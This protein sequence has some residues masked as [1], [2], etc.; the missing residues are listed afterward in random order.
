[1]YT[2]Y[3]GLTEAPFSIAPNPQYLF[4]SPRHRDALAH[5]LYGVQSDGGFILLTGEV[6]TGKTTLCR[7]LLQQVPEDV[8]TAFVLNPRVTITELL[9]TICDEFAISYPTD[10]SVKALVDA[11]NKFLLESHAAHRR[12]VLI[13]DEAQNL[14]FELLEQLRL[15]TNLETNDRK[16]LQIVLLGQP[17]LLEILAKRELR[18]LS[19]R[20]TAR[21]HLESLNPE[22]IRDYLAH[23]LA[24][25]GCREMLF[26][27]AAIKRVYKLS[28]GV[29]RVINLICDRALLGAYS[30][31]QRSVNR[32][33][34]NRAAEE[35]LGPADSRRRNGQ[36][37]AAIA[38][39]TLAIGVILTGILTTDSLSFGE[40]SVVAETPATTAD[41]K[42][43]QSIA[44]N[45]A[46]ESPVPTEDF[47]A[48]GHQE[49]NAAYHDL[50]ALWGSAFEDRTTHP[51]SLANA[52]G[53]QCLTEA[54]SFTELRAINRPVIIKTIDGYL[55][56]SVIDD[57]SVTLFA[58]TREYQ[59]T[60]EDFMRRYNDRVHMIWR[61]PPDYQAPIRSGDTG[62]AV[63]WLVIQLALMDNR[64]PPM[65]T[66]FVYDDLA[67][68]RVKAFQR[69]VGLTPNGIVDP[70]TW[71][72]LNNVEAISIP[73]LASTAGR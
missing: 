52:I 65:T 71:I 15:L 54:L 22:E 23:R 21:Y 37:A 29:P 38:V 34:V 12:A 73:T 51:C 41:E 66:G 72:H 60:H 25:A 14:S 28:R 27:R 7:C 70:L 5:L 67:E 46:S 57:S 48:T 43:L 2:E 31:D 30:E 8:D 16:L 49:I 1:M 36:K 68:A 39:V 69:T 6:G 11:L 53:L 33:I 62:A 40:R 44:A 24:I 59:L 32:A 55:T 17:E 18:Q 26:T 64:E 50:F 35:V 58:G 47:S 19:Q 3:F 10:A 61:M 9:A 42:P 45:E 4:M 20:I 13:I 63:D 56:V